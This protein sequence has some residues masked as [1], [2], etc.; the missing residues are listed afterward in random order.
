MAPGYRVSSSSAAASSRSCFDDSGILRQVSP[1]LIVFFADEG[2][3]LYLDDGNGR[4]YFPENRLFIAVT[5]EIIPEPATLCLLMLG[6]GT[7][8]VLRRR[9]FA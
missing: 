2:G 9:R 7:M 1:R 4:I 6:A 3:N 8:I 5:N